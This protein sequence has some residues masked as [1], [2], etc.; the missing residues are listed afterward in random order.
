MPNAN[1][2]TVSTLLASFTILAHSTTIPDSECDCFL[3]NGTAPTCFKFHG[4]WDFHSL[5]QYAVMNPLGLKL[6]V[7]ESANADSTTPYLN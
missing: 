5:A 3:I 7:E 2:A 6:S 1:I 4:F